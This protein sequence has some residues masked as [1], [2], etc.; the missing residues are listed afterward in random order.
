MSKKLDDARIVLAFRKCFDDLGGLV[1]RVGCFAHLARVPD[2]GKVS[3]KEDAIKLFAA[4]EQVLTL[5]ECLSIWA[6]GILGKRQQTTLN[7][8]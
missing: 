3:N 2:S 8:G 5:G 1:E 4:S 7:S 6:S